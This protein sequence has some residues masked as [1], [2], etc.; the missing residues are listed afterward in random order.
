MRSRKTVSRRRFVVSGAAG[1]AATAA[2]IGPAGAS[3]RQAATPAPVRATPTAEPGGPDQRDEQVLQQMTLEEKIARTHGEMNPNHPF[4]MPP[5]TRFGIPALTMAD[6]PSGVRVVDSNVNGGRATAMPATIG[7]AAT[8]DEA[9]ARRYGDLVG[10][11]AWST[12][13]N[14]QLGPGADIARVAVSGRI[15]ESF[16]EDPLL[17]GR[18]AA[19]YVT[20]IQTHPVAA[21]VKHYCVYNQEVDRTRYDAHLSERALREIYL[22]PFAAAVLEGNAGL[23]MGA[24]NQVNGFYACEHPVL[25]ADILKRQLAFPGFVIS[26]W[27]A[28]HGTVE[29]A[30]AGLDQE[31]PSARVFGDALQAAVQTG[32]VPMARLDDMA[33]RVLRTMFARDLVDHPV[34]I[35]PLPEQ[36]HGQIAREIAA[37]GIVLLKNN[38]RLLPLPSGGVRSIAVIGA[39]ADNASAAGGGSGLAAPTYTVSPLDGIGQRAGAAIAVEHAPGTDPV[40]AAALLPGPQPVPSSVLTPPD[41]DPC[42]HGLRAEYWD[43]PG[44]EGDPA[45]VRTDPHVDLNF[46]FFVYRGF[47]AGSPNL[48]PTPGPSMAGPGA[49]PSVRWTGT[50]TAPATGDYV[51]AL[52]SLG[53]SR[54]VLDGQPLIDNL[55]LDLRPATAAVTLAGGEP[56]EVQIEYAADAAGISGN[57]GAQMR[58][59][60]EHPAEAIPSRVREAADLASRCDVA[61]V[62]VRDYESEEM[63]RPDLRLP[64][65]QDQ[66][67][68]AV[69]AA[70]PKTIVVVQTGAAVT[71]PWLDDVGAVVQ[72]WY[73][74]QE[75]GNA[76]ADILFGDV[77]PSGKLPLTF[78]QSMDE[79]PVATEAQYPGVMGI[80]EYSEDVFVGYRGYEHF[81]I[82]P[83]FTF[84]HGL[85]YTTF[86]YADLRVE[87]VGG[88]TGGAGQTKETDKADTDTVARVTFT[89]ANSGEVAG[90]EVAQIYVG[91]LPGDVAMPPKQLAGFAKVTLDPGQR[92]DITVDV[93]RSALSYWDSARQG[94]T[95]PG[96]ETAVYVGS[97]S[98][99]I[100]LEGMIRIA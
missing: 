64:N 50:L 30:N 97:S 24:F 96:G 51:L 90:A 52:T 32:A 76:I 6:G 68:R 80:V 58:F 89:L 45:L 69:A 47:N 9:L 100:R 82:E 5:L 62:V 55:G 75:Q 95:T 11:E 87:S 83:L 66:L 41:A 48:P 12:G 78:P 33:R 99:D 91:P 71:M 46:G 92:Q 14:V 93:P 53:S 77:N 70:N 2:M 31:Q 17:S 60:W 56:H 84:G 27:G 67:I 37:Q 98:Q 7:L 38:D 29:S 22:P 28:A 54:L 49:L 40:S 21:C 25:L 81:G 85:S 65:E 72:A 4:Y 39:D 88:A 57:I 86:D 79:T 3:E 20:G 44:F 59:G 18:C 8:W 16:G 34:E 13:H 15:F 1:A 35:R 23:V 61:V 63:D 10:R 26:D 36:E 42:V 94:W 43:N 74:G 73:G 19:A